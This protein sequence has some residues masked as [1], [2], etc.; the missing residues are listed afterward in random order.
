MKYDQKG[1]SYLDVRFRDLKKNSDR[2]TLLR[3]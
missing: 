1:Q 3:P 2:L